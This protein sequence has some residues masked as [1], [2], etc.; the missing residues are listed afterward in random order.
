MYT[1]RKSSLKLC[2]FDYHGT[3]L[4]DNEVSYNPLNKLEVCSIL[5]HSVDLTVKRHCHNVKYFA[6]CFNQGHSISL[7][8]LQIEPYICHT[9]STRGK[10]ASRFISPD[11]LALDRKNKLA[12]SNVWKL[13]Q[14]SYTH[15]PFS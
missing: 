4:W 12:H 3:G 2:P 1:E 13:H 9:C 6:I 7:Y 8:L 14:L 5:V 15:W 10:W 11:A